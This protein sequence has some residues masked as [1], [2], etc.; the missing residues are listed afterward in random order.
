MKRVQYVAD[1]IGTHVKG[2]IMRCPGCNALFVGPKNA[3]YCSNRC[4]VRVA[5]RM[6]NNHD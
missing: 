1:L 5:R 6:E 4:R 2:W 3:L